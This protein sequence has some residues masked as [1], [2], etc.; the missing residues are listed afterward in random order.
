MKLLY[1]VIFSIIFCSS[2]NAAIFPILW[3]PSSKKPIPQTSSQSFPSVKGMNL[4]GDKFLLPGDLSAE[5]NIVIVPFER[6]QQEDVN[7][8]IEALDGFVAN[9]KEIELYELPTLKNFNLFMRLIINNGMRYGID[10]KE[11]REH[12]ITLYLDKESFKSRLSIPNENQIQI[13]LINQQGEIFWRE[14]GLANAQKIQTLKSKIP[15]L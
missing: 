15:M 1:S 10:S 9:N 5:L 8:W 12:T 7:T 3:G 2:A 11:S 13:F 14:S 4:E 6:T